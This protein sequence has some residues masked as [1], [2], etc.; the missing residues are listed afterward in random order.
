MKIAIVLQGEKGEF[1]SSIMADTDSEKG[2]ILFYDKDAMIGRQGKAIVNISDSPTSK[3]KIIETTEKYDK[4]GNLVE[5]NTREEETEDD[6]V[7][8]GLPWHT[9]TYGHGDPESEGEP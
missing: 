6:T 3:T 2:S 4:D 8:G 7:Y 9:P 5:K 1:Q